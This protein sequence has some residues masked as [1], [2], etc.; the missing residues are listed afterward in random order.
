MMHK[1][2]WAVLSVLLIAAMLFNLGG[3]AA[4][5][6]TTPTDPTTPTN[7][8]PPAAS[9]SV[10]LMAGFTPTSA[11]DASGMTPEALAAATDFALR[12]FRAGN[13]PGENTL[14]SPLS[15]LCALA[16]TA[17]GANGETLTQME[18]T[19]GLPRDRY[20][21]FFHSC[22]AALAEG[23]GGVLSLANAIWFT[24]DER[25]TVNRDFLQTNADYYGAGAY[26]A[27]FDETTLRDINNWVGQK[28][29]G[30]IPEILDQIPPEA[31]MYLVNALAFDAKWQTPYPEYAVGQGSFTAASGET[32]TVEY[33]YSEEHCYLEDEN[34]TGFLKRYAGGRYAF[35]ALL[36]KEGVSV[37]AYL[38]TLDGAHLQALVTEPQDVPVLTSLP[39]FET[40]WSGELSD[41]LVSMGMTDA[42]D[43]TL[44]DFS[45]LGTST[46]GNIFINRVI[47]K[48]FISVTEGGTR[49]GAATVV[50]MTDGVAMMD[51]LKQVYLDRPF[52]YLLIDCESGLPIFIGTMN[53][54]GQ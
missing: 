33:L 11:P 41:L 4:A 32:R 48:T 53:D 1:K 34:A 30:M 38:E 43:S 37:E 40:A 25:F 17:N 46:G 51:E 2:L 15:V 14:I 45:G 24:S 39:K 28:T 9:G 10:D 36:P 35:A 19:L 42:F 22:L 52:V 44:A 3:C 12:L 31:V 8:N 5:K 29:D 27:P 16:M 23:D 21:A 26:R 7:P 6:P 13:T 47:H 20:N 54:P 49:A 18:H 50:E